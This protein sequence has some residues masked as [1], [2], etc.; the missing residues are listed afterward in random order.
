M[1]PGIFPEER[2]S[3]GG[4]CVKLT[5]FIPPCIDGHEI[6]E[7]QPPGTLRIYLSVH[8]DFYLSYTANEVQF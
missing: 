4:R 2:G 7:P 8:R 5:N 6:W 3:K 1:I